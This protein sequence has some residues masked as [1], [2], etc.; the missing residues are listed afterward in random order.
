[1]TAL[2][3]EK[4]RARRLAK[5]QSFDDLPPVGSYRDQIRCGMLPE[6][7]RSRPR[8]HQ[9][10][11]PSSSKNRTSDFDQLNR[12]LQ[13]A[14]H[15]DARRWRACQKADDV[16]IR[17]KLIARC[18]AWPEG[19]GVLPAREKAL[20]ATALSVVASLTH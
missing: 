1:M 18:Q 19:A 5:E 2:N 13:H 15:P 10:L 4:D 6:P 9:T 20:I 16:Q 3:W 12:Y 17:K 14:L 8:D 7:C 11:V